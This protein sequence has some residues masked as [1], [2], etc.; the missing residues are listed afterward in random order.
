MKNQ[1]AIED[2]IDYM[3][4]YDSFGCLL[5]D[6]YKRNALEWVLGGEPISDAGTEISG[7]I[8]TPEEIQQV[9]GELRADK[10]SIAEYSKWGDPNWLNIDAQIAELTW[11]LED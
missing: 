3:I 1:A 6:Y 10:N 2:R 11:V 5:R 9:I 8:A 4:P 7:T